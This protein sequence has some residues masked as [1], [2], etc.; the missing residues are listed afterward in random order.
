MVLCVP[1]VPA[2]ATYRSPSGP[3]LNPRG[4]SRREATVNGVGSIA[5]CAIDGTGAKLPTA[6]AT[7]SA[8]DNDPMSF[9]PCSP[10]LAFFGVIQPE[11]LSNAPQL[12]VAIRYTPVKNQRQEVLSGSRSR[13][14]HCCGWLR[15]QTRWRGT[16]LRRR[17]EADRALREQNGE[18]GVHMTHPGGRGSG[19]K[20][21]I[22]LPSG[23]RNSIDR[24]PQG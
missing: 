24:L 20:K 6:D 22:R 14:S 23:S 9:I 10:W 21:L 3:N 19:V 5:G 4:P 7:M 2:S 1:P 8:V 12:R 17:S 15:Y 11:L 13:V 16:E 18:S